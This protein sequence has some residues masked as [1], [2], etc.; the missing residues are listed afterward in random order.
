MLR[1]ICLALVPGLQ[2]EVSKSSFPSDRSGFV[3]P[4]GSP[5][6][7]RNKGLR[8]LESSFRMGLGLPPWRLGF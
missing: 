2:E 5:I 1:G 8:G 4:D 3:I 7:G 6:L